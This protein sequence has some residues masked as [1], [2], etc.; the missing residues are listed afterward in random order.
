MRRGHCVGDA[1]HVF[2][3]QHELVAAQ[4]GQRV[5]RSHHHSQPV[6][7]LAQHRV[8]GSVAEAVVD[9]L[10][11]VEVDEQQREPR[12]HEARRALEAAF[13]PRHRLAQPVVEQRAVRDAGQH[14]VEGHALQFGVGDRQRLREARRAGLQ[15][16]VERR[17]EQGDR[18]Q[19]HH[20]HQDHDAEAAAAEAVGAEAQRTGREAGRGHARIV[21]A[22]DRESHHHRCGGLC[23]ACLQAGQAAHSEEDQQGHGG[24]AAGDHARDRQPAPVPDD[25]GRHLHRCHAGVVHRADAGAHRERAE[26]QCLLRQPLAAGDQQCER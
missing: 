26:Q 8:A 7:H 25:A 11:A 3:Q 21:H 22:A 20:G 18:Q 14:V 17:R 23:G 12:G 9:R 1:G 15:P 10:E 13:D 5:G 24:S 16:R 2:Q 6:R 4:P 19:Q